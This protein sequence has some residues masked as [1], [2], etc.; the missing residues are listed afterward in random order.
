MGEDGVGGGGG[1][2][3]ERDRIGVE[4]EGRWERREGVWR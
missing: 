1:G 2:E 3:E 4:R